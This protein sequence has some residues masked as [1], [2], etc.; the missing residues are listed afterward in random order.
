MTATS[1]PLEAY[2]APVHGI[3]S[4]SSN[5]MY[6]P[7]EIRPGEWECQCEAQIHH[8]F[9]KCQHILR[10]IVGRKDSVIAFLI[11][12]KD[13][14][15]DAWNDLEEIVKYYEDEHD[16]EMEF[17]GRRIL[18][19][20]LRDPIVTGDSL[21]R[22]LG[23]K[24]LENPGMIGAAFQSLQHKKWITKV[25]YHSSKKKNNH[26]SVAFDWVISDEGRE[27]L[28]YVP[29]G[30]APTTPQQGGTP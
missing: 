30:N 20:G 26:G 14:P 23:E 17:L 10:L 25:G 16:V 19:L 13:L 12:V 8:P 3:P 18:K 22:E 15:E 9:G 27:A 7:R 24:T 29:L 6:F 5:R 11:E 4:F 1:R 21:S 28:K 2:D